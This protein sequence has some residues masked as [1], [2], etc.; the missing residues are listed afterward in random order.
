MTT[1]YQLYMNKLPGNVSRM[2]YHLSTLAERW[3]R[4]RV[5]QRGLRSSHELQV[6]NG[7]IA[8]Y[9]ALGSFQQVYERRY[10]YNHHRDNLYRSI[11]DGQLRSQ[12]NLTDIMI[13]EVKASRAD[14]MSTFGGKV[15]NGH[16]NRHYPVGSHHWIVAPKGLITINEVPTFW[17]LLE[18]S[19]RGLREVIKPY[20][21]DV[22]RE[23]E[24]GFANT[25]LWYCKSAPK[26]IDLPGQIPIMDRRRVT[27]ERRNGIERRILREQ[28]SGS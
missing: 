13:F 3:L 5:T 10:W 4:H 26:I 2:H 12:R 28:S 9:V 18:T 15:K 6:G 21:F 25:I 23:D 24:L 17:G 1:N 16:K 20:W 7:Y 8:D 19:G 14:F 11:G 27:T 22:T